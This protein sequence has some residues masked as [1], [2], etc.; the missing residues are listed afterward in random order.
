MKKAGREE[1]EGAETNGVSHI[2]PSDFRC[3]EGLQSQR[4]QRSVLICFPPELLCA[5]FPSSLLHSSGQLGW[6]EQRG[7][8]SGARERCT[9]KGEGSEAE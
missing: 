3:Q 4:W 6:G 9:G 7:L 8:G 5:F 1:G 2:H